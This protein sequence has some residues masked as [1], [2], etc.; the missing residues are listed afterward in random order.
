MAKAQSKTQ[1][2]TDNNIRLALIAVC[3]QSLK[4][5]P[6]FKWLTH[7]VDFTNF[8]ASLLVTCIFE[9]QE[10]LT[11]AEQNLHTQQMQNNVQAKLFKI[12]VKVS[13]P[14]NQV[15]FDT[16]EACTQ[17]HEGDWKTRLA[18]KKGRALARNRPNGC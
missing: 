12:G 4:D 3:E 18:S 17:E 6:G 7:Q 13:S 9:T 16:E 10:Q 11:Q 1:K 15:V 5:I 8:P 2:R 14:K